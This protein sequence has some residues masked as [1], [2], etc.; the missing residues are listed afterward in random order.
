VRVDETVTADGA[1]KVTVE[2]Q[3]A[4]DEDFTAPVTLMTSVAIPKA[5]LIQGYDAFAVPTRPTASSSC[6]STTRWRTG[7]SRRASSPRTSD[8]RS[9]TTPRRSTRGQLGRGSER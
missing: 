1:A 4:S 3:T 2:L 8:R 7:P 5:A 9:A 6:G